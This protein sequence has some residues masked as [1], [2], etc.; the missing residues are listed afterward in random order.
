MLLALA[1]ALVIGLSLAILGSGGSIITLPVLVYVAGIP[2]QEAVGMSL[3]IV[4]GTSLIASLFNARGGLI[5]S[6]AA[7]LFSVNGIVCAL[8]VRR[9][10]NVNF[11]AG[12]TYSHDVTLVSRFSPH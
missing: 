5:H 7:M 1:L 9:S 4:G 12:R 2:A 6:K 3:A 11:R 8:D 10:S